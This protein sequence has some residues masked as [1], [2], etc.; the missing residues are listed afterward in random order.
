M[1]VDKKE[2]N[3]ITEKLNL[4]EELIEMIDD[5]GQRGWDY[6]R[7]QE[8]SERALNWKSVAPKNVKD[9]FDLYLEWIADG[10]FSALGYSRMIY[11]A[12]LGDRWR[13]II[14]EGDTK[15]LATLMM[16]REVMAVAAKHDDMATAM[17]L[18]TL[19]GVKAELHMEL[20]DL[21]L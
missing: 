15:F 13:M 8:I 17:L 3:R 10:K 20:S 18:G 16:K 21:F 6:S 5:K 9:D 4:L 1:V 7:V 2:A 14:E 19:Y 11:K 12:L